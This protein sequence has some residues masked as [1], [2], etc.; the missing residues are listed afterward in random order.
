MYTMQFWKLMVS[1]S[2]F[3]Q[4]STLIHQ[5]VEPPTEGQKS[6]ILSF[7]ALEQ[8]NAIRL[9]Q[10]CVCDKTI[11]SF[12]LNGVCWFLCVLCMFVKRISLKSTGIQHKCH[13]HN[14]LLN[15]LL[16]WQA[17]PHLQ[18]LT[19]A[20]ITLELFKFFHVAATHTQFIYTVFNYF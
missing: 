18:C 14:K 16:I 7:I 19:K 6:P 10:V 12:C 2:A 8:F 20:F 13:W 5:K 9:V 4:G 3:Y 15:Q 17:L 1:L 11:F